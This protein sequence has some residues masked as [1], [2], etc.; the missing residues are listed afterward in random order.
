[1]ETIWITCIPKGMFTKTNISI[2]DIMIL[3]MEAHKCVPIVMEIGL[4]ILM[5]ANPHQIMFSY[6]ET[7]ISKLGITRNKLLLLCH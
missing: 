3:F 5:T 1:M 7:V 6:W 2:L 4:T